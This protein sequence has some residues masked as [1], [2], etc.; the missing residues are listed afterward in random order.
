MSVLNY[1]LITQ[2]FLELLPPH[3]VIYQ[4]KLQISCYLLQGKKELL[5]SITTFMVRNKEGLDKSMETSVLLTHLFS[6]SW[7][8]S[9]FGCLWRSGWQWKSI[10]AQIW[11]WYNRMHKAQFQSN[12]QRFCCLILITGAGNQ[13]PKSLLYVRNTLSET[14]MF[15]IQWG[16]RLIIWGEQ[17]N[18]FK[19]M[20]S[21]YETYSGS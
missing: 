10:W 3:T 8:I 4:V 18:Y 9:V 19:G 15:H 11:H 7:Y 13:K 20:S 17:Q 6:S 16:R 12:E 14:E 21:N 2:T 1:P 5:W